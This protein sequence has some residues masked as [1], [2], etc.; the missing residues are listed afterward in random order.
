MEL[1]SLL[2]YVIRV[3]VKSCRIFF[4]YFCYWSGINDKVATM[5][6]IVP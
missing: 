2:H 5:L 3:C 1:L 4:E 6:G